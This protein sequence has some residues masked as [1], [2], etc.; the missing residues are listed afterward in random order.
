[1]AR[2]GPQTHEHKGLTMHEV[3]TTCDVCGWIW[4]ARTWMRCPRCMGHCKAYEP[5]Q[6]EIRQACELIRLGWPQHKLASQEGHAEEL[7]IT[8]V[9]RVWDH[10]VRN[11]SRD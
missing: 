7:E 11:D 8:E 2:G 1:M 10:M 3:P 4:D 9:T 5:S 6:A